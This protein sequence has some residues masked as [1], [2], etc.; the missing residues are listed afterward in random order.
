MTNVA[1]RDQLRRA[2]ST[3]CEDAEARCAQLSEAPELQTQLGGVIRMCAQVE[4]L[5]RDVVIPEDM[6]DLNETVLRSLQAQLQV[7]DARIKHTAENGLRARWPT[8]SE[9]H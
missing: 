5:L 4:L 6:L 3:I 7:F 8:I 9:G 2:A 1:R